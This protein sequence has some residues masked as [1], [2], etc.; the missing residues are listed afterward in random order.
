MYF[1]GQAIQVQADKMA[2]YYARKVPRKPIGPT[3]T[4]PWRVRAGG[5]ISS[6][7]HSCRETPCGH[8]TLLEELRQ[9]WLVDIGNMVKTHLSLLGGGVNVLERH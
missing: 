4:N 8:S 5:R 2:H 3:R 9:G 7:S 6:E 1:C